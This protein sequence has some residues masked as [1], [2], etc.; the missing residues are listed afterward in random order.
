MSQEF[1][2][3]DVAVIIDGSHKYHGRLVR[4]NA[5]VSSGDM[6]GSYRSYLTKSKDDKGY[7]DPTEIF[8]YPH[9]LLKV[10]DEDKALITEKEDTVAGDGIVLNID[11]I[12]KYLSDN[13]IRQI[14]EKVLTKKI[15]ASVDHILSNQ[16]RY[17]GRTELDIVFE[18]VAKMYADKFNDKYADTMVK[19][20]EEI[21]GGEMKKTYDGEYVDPL[22]RSMQKYLENFAQEYINKHPDEIRNMIWP[23][24]ERAGSNIAQSTI[25]DVIKRSINLENIVNKLV[26]EA[27]TQKTDKSLEG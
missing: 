14:C 27:S 23:Q 9:Q 22:W 8:L 2:V 17:I 25:V 11:F 10:S 24:V 20:F 1:N 12:Q 26:A 16:D 4:I 19:R 13:E 3:S 6:A 7:P 21:I 5:M 15:S 18:H